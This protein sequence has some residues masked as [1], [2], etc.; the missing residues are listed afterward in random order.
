[1]GIR[2]DALD[3]L[4]VSAGADQAKLSDAKTAAERAGTDLLSGIARTQA[5][6]DKLL[7]KAL[8][9]MTGLPVLAQVS[10]D[11][12]DVDLVRRV[13]M[14]FARDQGILPL[15]ERDGIIEVA[16]G[17]PASLPSVDDFRVLFSRPVKPWIMGPGQLSELINAAYDAASRTASAVIDEIEEEEGYVADDLQLGDDLLDDP[18]QAPIIRFVNSLLTQAIKERHPHRTVRERA[19]RPLSRGWR[20]L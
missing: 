11:D 5:V 13:P 9:T 20:A 17:S 15:W 6:D 10:V 4:L 8:G 2:R 3:V 18:N 7:A 19:Q 1:M 12:I 16:L 14:G